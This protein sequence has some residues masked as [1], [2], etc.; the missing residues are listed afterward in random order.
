MECLL[1][2]RAIVFQVRGCPKKH[3]GKRQQHA[4][5]KGNGGYLNEL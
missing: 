5:K 3:D 1:V 2:E 4:T